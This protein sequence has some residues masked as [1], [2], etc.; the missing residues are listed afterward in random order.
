[1]SQPPREYDYIIVGAGSAGC[2]L[3]N[4][5]G[6]DTSKSIL[7]L[8]AGPMDR[9]L[10]IH[11]PA[12]VYRTWCDPKLNWNYDT[13]P[14][15]AA[16]DREIFM[17]RGKVVG[18][19]SSINS[20]VYMRGHPLDYDGWAEEFGLADWRYENCLPYFRAGE[21][22]SRGGDAY[23]GDAGPLGVTRG[24]YENPLY[25]AFIEAGAQAGQ[26]RSDDLNG[27]TP[28]G[29]ARFDATKRHG[30]RCSAAV[31]HL[32]P[33]LERGNVTLLTGAAVQRIELSSNRA[34]GVRVL[35]RGQ[36]QTFH[37][38]HD[39]ILSGGAIN[40]PQLLMLSG[41]GPAAHLSEM[42]IE[43]A[44]DLSGVGANLQDHA[45]VIVQCKSRVSFP[46]HRVDRPWNK[47]RAGA[48]WVFAR[49]GVA[50]S[51]I[52][53]A[54]GLIRGNA[55]VAYPNLQ[56][57]FGPV[58]FEYN[59]PKITLLQAFAC[60]VDQLRPRSRGTLRLASTDPADNPD[61]QFNYL[62]DPHDLDELVEGIHRVRDLIGQCAFDPFRDVEID[63]GPDVTT[64]TQIR[65]WIRANVTT[66]FHP[67]G[68]C[69][70]GHG[71]DAVVD[72]RFRVHG[73]EG[74]RVVDASIMPRVISANLNAPTQ[75]IAARAADYIAEHPQLAP[76][77]PPFAFQSP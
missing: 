68:T 43:V 34:T 24:D 53:E 75:M 31:A 40:S 3:A 47:L 61:L 25:D 29:V 42:G 63:P 77:T 8:E 17:P 15:P 65:N 46:I 71:A 52:W 13:A 50:A 20:M 1:M 66:D 60:H 38:A 64:D 57:H 6:Q 11:I 70:M 49:N 41:I 74:L 18:G 30:R 33:A 16:Q 21:T 67:C 36:A 14:E 10:F 22:Y 5:L 73:V 59:G 28:E 56:Y 35:Y 26:G 9:D 54:G 58:G 62:S 2:T 32:S 44:N 76:E 45:S 69:R 37:A 48:Q 51:N 7:V 4:K 72:D 23:R 27:H 12:G 19:S 39:V 55:D